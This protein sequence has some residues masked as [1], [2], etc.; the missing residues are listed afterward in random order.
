MQIPNGSAGSF[1]FICVATIGVCV[2]G[3]LTSVSALF[4]FLEHTMEK[5]TREQLLDELVSNMFSRRFTKKMRQLFVA[6]I[7]MEG[8]RRELIE[9]LDLNQKKL[10]LN[11]TQKRINFYNIGNEILD[12]DEKKL[13]KLN[14]QKSK[15][16]KKS[17]KA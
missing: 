15:N 7:E 16:V 4:Y 12:E 6:R 8:A 5:K 3:A 10:F 17:T 14:K 2:F 9:T 11:Y 13:E 1:L